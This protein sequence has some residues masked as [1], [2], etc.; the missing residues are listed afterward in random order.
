MKARKKIASRTVVIA[1]L[2]IDSGCDCLRRLTGRQSTERPGR[3]AQ[4]SRHFVLAL[5]RGGVTLTVGP[6]Q[7]CSE[8]ILMSRP[9]LAAIP[10]PP[11]CEPTAREW[12]ILAL[13]A[14][15]CGNPMIGAH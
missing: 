7:N 12:Q 13:I 10:L 8:V 6:G 1:R 5:T 14:V 2:T 3:C 15:G 9:R 4:H 11:R